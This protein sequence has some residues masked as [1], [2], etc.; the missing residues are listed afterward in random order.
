MAKGLEL[1][2]IKERECSSVG[3]SE[4]RWKPLGMAFQFVRLELASQKLFS[5]SSVVVV[6]M[7]GMGMRRMNFIYLELLSCKI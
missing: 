5:S 4:W 3:A 6:R 1:C 2:V 7:A